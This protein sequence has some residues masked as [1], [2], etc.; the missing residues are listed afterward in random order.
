L[1]QAL[2]DRGVRSE[3]VSLSTG[4]GPSQ[5]DVRVLARRSLSPVA[6]WRLNAAARRV[7]VV[8]AHGSRTLLACALATPTSGVPFVYKNIGDTAYWSRSTLRRVR[9]GAAL[10]RAAVVVAMTTDAKR[11]LH[12]H[13]GLP[14]ESV[15]VIPSWRSASRFR[16]VTAAQRREARQ[17]LGLSG[18]D[19]V[20]L[21]LGALAPEKR[22][23]LAI[24]AVA[25][26]AGAKLLVA[27]Y[28]PERGALEA[29]ASS[30]MPGRV[31]F[32]GLVDRPEEVLRAADVVVQSSASE[33]VPGVLIEAGL[34]ALPVVA[35]DV[36]GVS[37][38]VDNGRTGLLVQPGDVAGLR[39]AC[40]AVLVSPDSMGRNGRERCAREFDMD[41]VVDRW[42]ELLERVA[43]GRTSIP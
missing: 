26:I 7:D 34:S 3:I 5:L 1:D 14:L 39:R 38:V 13:H 36:G 6:L 15:V 32:T 21:V 29:T 19:P 18:D 30:R 9:V 22:V 42:L 40:E 4:D 23:D 16:P 28:G 37:A 8:V 2:R 33:G 43:L 27:G 25:G 35:F 41:Q 20:F 17:A 24:E 10:R 31:V 12:E 11:S